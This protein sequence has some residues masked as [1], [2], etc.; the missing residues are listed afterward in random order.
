MIKWI[1][2]KNAVKKISYNF[3]ENGINAIHS[4][5]ILHYE[6]KKTIIRDLGYN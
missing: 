6:K 3:K 5:N 4:E 1:M 2:T